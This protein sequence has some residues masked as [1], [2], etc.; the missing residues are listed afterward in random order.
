MKRRI[1]YMKKGLCIGIGLVLIVCFAAM[2]YAADPFSWTKY[3]GQT[4]RLLLNKHGYTD[5]ML[6]ELANFTKLT[7]I[8]VT[9]DIYPEEQ[10]FDKVTVA[11]SSG[12]SD[13]DVYMTGAYQVWQYAPPGWV[14]PLEKYISD[15]SV[16]NPQY[17]A[18][19]L[20]PNLMASLRWDTKDGDMT[21]TGHQWA[22]P[23]GFEENTLMYNKKIFA[24]L[25]LSP[26]KTFAEV[27]R[28]GKLVEQKYPG[29]VGI[30]VRGSRN[31]ATIHPGFLT[32]F[33]SAG[34]SDYDSS[35]TPMMNTPLGVRYAKAWVDMIK[36][37]GPSQWT[38]YTWYDVGNALGAGKAAMIFDADILG[39]FQ[40]VPGGSAESG[41]IAWAVGPG[42]DGP[43]TKANVWIWSLS[44]NAAS[45]NKIP[46]WYWLQWATGKDF[47]TTAAVK[48]TLVD[49]VRQSVWNDPAFQ[50]R[51]AGFTGYLDTF[52]A[53][54]K[55]AR[56]YFTAQSHFQETTT[57]WAAALQEIWGGADSKA[58]LDKLVSTLKK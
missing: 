28:D 44:M 27:I 57:E 29:V 13:Y 22:L 53:L 46:A 1:R 19:D 16:T 26:P 40:N 10:Y 45:K 50:K 2:A 4:V 42:L 14:E 20:L 47:L 39:F 25:K 36:Q 32:G 9:Y 38:T 34:G 3:K 43:A 56:V 12:S 7:G 49:P 15:P 48:Y 58:T 41:N 18:A 6:Q 23:W 21:G 55:D 24:D 33:V 31:W 30:A 52:K 5:S 51:L 37:V 8:K 35:M 11:L 54:A 17:D